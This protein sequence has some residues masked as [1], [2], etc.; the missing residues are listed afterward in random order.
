MIGGTSAGE[1]GPARDPVPEQP[2]DSYLVP[3]IARGSAQGDTIPLAE[4]ARLVGITRRYLRR[5]A[6]LVGITTQHHLG[7][8]GRRPQGSSGVDPRSSGDTDHWSCDV[9]VW[10]SSCTDAV[11][12]GWNHLVRCDGVH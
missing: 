2:E 9:T 7:H 3:V 12:G 6:P 8:A 11:I 4:A 10:L 1:P 5:L